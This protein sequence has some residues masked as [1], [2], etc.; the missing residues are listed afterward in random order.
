MNKHWSEIME[1]QHHTESDL[2]E[3]IEELRF[4]EG[5]RNKTSQ[6]ISG[7]P[8]YTSNTL[9]NADHFRIT[10]T[11]FRLSSHRWKWEGGA[12]NQLNYVCV[13]VK[14]ASKMKDTYLYALAHR[15]SV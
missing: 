7:H 5:A 10:V 15:I 2:R 13:A 3:M 4:N 1:K 12:V 9:Y 14:L 11:R 8:F 6:D